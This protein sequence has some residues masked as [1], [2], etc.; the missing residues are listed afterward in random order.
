M[1]KEKTCSGVDF[2]KVV[3]ILFNQQKVS[4]SN[5]STE[6]LVGISQNFQGSNF[7]ELFCRGIFRALPNI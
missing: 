7:S 2:C 3:F 6:G 1:F 5:T 4:D